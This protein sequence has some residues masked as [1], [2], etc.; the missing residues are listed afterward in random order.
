MQSQYSLLISHFSFLKCPLKAEKWLRKGERSAFLATSLDSVWLTDGD[1][2]RDVPSGS[3]G[4][5]GAFPGFLL[6]WLVFERR[7]VGV[8]DEQTDSRV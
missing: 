6:S 1:A 2:G 5:R 7:A 8:G 4:C 3:G